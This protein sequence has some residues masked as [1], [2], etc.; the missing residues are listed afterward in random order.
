MYYII[1]N[2]SFT[3]GIVK[4]YDLDLFREMEKMDKKYVDKNYKILIALSITYKNMELANY[5][6]NKYYTYL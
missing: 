4:F 3:L 5:L 1:F 6:I 2:S